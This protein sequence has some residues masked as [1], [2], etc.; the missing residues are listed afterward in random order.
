MLMHIEKI[1]M[2]SK[3]KSININKILMDIE[4]ILKHLVFESL[5][6][7]NVLIDLAF[8]PVGEI[9]HFLAARHCEESS[10]KQSRRLSIRSRLLRYARNDR[11]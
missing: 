8:V 9:P 1:L 4:L 6:F 7:E 5:D 11:A 3:K 10:T 2:H